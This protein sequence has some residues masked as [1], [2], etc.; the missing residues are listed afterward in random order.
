MVFTL[1]PSIVQADMADERTG[2]QQIDTSQDK[3]LDKQVFP[4]FL[5]CDVIYAV[6]RCLYPHDIHAV[7]RWSYPLVQSPSRV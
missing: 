1:Y 5:A 4:S 2:G 6:F 7:F 3:L